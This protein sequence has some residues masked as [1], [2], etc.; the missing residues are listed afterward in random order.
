MVEIVKVEIVNV[1]LYFLLAVKGCGLCTL[2]SV[3][4]IKA[5]FIH[6]LDK[7]QR[8]LYMHKSNIYLRIRLL[9]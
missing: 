1:K 6:S 5:I 8:E 7:I 9:N 4:C 2:M 3:P